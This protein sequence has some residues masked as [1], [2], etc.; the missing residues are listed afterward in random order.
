VIAL[1]DL[2]AKKKQLKKFDKRFGLGKNSNQKVIGIGTTAQ[3]PQHQKATIKR[4]RL[5]L[6][7]MHQMALAPKSS[8]QQRRDC[9]LSCLLA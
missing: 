3:R 2:G 8:N 4:G 9:V 5:A 6:A 1:N 7:P